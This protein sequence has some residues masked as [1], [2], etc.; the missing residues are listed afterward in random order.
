MRGE[1]I[2]AAGIGWVAHL[3]RQAQQGFVG[4]DTDG[5]HQIEGVAVSAKQNMLAIVE[6]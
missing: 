1:E 2:H 4:T 6:R 3:K 5:V